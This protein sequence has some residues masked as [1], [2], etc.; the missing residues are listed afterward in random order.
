[1]GRERSLQ[2][3]HTSEGPAVPVEPTVSQWRTSLQAK[4]WHPGAGLPWKVRVKGTDHV[5]AKGWALQGK[6]PWAAS[7]T[8]HCLLFQELPLPSGFYFL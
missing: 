5:N 3:P 1:M 8:D 7:R 4:S 2:S 6:P